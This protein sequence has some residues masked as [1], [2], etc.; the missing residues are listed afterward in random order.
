MKVDDLVGVIDINTIEY[1]YIIND[2]QQMTKIDTSSNKTVPLQ[3]TEAFFDSKKAVVKGQ[4]CR[5]LNLEKEIVISL[6][7][8]EQKINREE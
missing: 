5:K 3:C 1:Y 6:R 2:E 7:Q 8:M 4:K